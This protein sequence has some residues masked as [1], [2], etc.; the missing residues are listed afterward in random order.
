[1]LNIRGLS[2]GK[3]INNLGGLGTIGGCIMVGRGGARRRGYRDQCA[4]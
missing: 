2:L 1:M 3:W 4:A